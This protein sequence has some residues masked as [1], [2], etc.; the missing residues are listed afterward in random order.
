MQLALLSSVV[1]GPSGQL[2]FRPYPPCLA[3][4]QSQSNPVSLASSD[5]TVLVRETPLLG[6]GSLPP[7][8]QEQKAAIE[9]IMAAAI[10]GF[11]GS[12]LAG[13]GNS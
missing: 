6:P 9:S 5:A 12:I 4:D 1:P 3:F 7:P 2:T 10:T 11:I 13:G 8:P